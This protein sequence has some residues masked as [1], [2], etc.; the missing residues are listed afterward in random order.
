MTGAGMGLVFASGSLILMAYF[1]K[2]I[3]LALGLASSGGSVGLK[4]PNL[5]NNG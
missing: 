5:Q 1:S 2:H 4:P 3:G